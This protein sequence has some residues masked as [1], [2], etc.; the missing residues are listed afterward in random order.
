MTVKFGQDHGT[1]VVNKQSPNK[2]IW[3]SS[4]YRYENFIKE[5][6]TDINVFYLYY[7]CF[8]S[9]PKRYDFINDRWIYKHDGTCLHDLLSK[10][11]SDILKR[12]I[13]FENCEYT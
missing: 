9:G 3:L 1:Y 11:I 4:P 13:S 2:Q 5:F 8:F 10:E 6:K 7:V 12:P